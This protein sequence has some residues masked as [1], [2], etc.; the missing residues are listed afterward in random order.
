MLSSSKTSGELKGVKEAKAENE[1]NI[2]TLKTSPLIGRTLNGLFVLTRLLNEF[3]I[4]ILELGQ[5]LR[6]ISVT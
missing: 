4:L 5:L 1:K 3:S 6:Q 2:Y